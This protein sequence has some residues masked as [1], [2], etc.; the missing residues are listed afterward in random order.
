[1]SIRLGVWSSARLCR[2]FTVVVTA[3][4][5]LV[6]VMAVPVS[7]ASATPAGVVLR[8]GAA[9]N[10]LGPGEA[11]YPGEMLVSDNNTYAL[12]MQTDGNLVL[13]GPSG[14]IWATRTYGRPA[15]SVHM[16]GD[17][18]LVVYS[19]S[20]P[21]WLTGTSTYP[22]AHLVL[23]GDGNLVLYYGSTPLWATSWHSVWGRTK[24]T[25]TGG[26]G[27]CT[28]YAYDRFKAFS[29][30]YPDLSGDAVDWDNAARAANWLVLTQ[31]ITQAIV[32]FERGYR[33]RTPPGVTS[34]GRTG[35]S[36]VL[37]VSTCTSSR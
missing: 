32:V 34:P 17:G 29:G 5:L 11:L 24:P 15:V 3:V 22:G 28:W 7:A 14:A 26:Y 27:Y 33:A 36:T 8:A 20:T 2:P 18:H 4:A 9:R 12:A 25:N 10:A 21:I 13:Y 1:M 19:G 31:P 23:Q 35:W 6:G 30:V 37:T 16:Q